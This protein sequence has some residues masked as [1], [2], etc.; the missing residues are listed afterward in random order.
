[1]ESIWKNYD[2]TKLSL[3][4]HPEIDWIPFHSSGNITECS[5]KISNYIVHNGANS[6][7]LHIWNFFIVI[8][9]LSEAPLF[10]QAG[11]LGIISQLSN[12]AVFFFG[13][14]ALSLPWDT[15]MNQ[16]SWLQAWLLS[17]ISFFWPDFFHAIAI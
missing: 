10:F 2:Y 13:V 7:L 17:P 5:T 9:F 8:S 16:A 1:M 6:H 15:S 3:C 12:P 4:F 11:N 14:L